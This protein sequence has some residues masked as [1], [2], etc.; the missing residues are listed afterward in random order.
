MLKFFIISVLLILQNFSAFAQ[1]SNI[2]WLRKNTHEFTDLSFIDEAVSKKQFVFLGESSHGAKE[3]YSLKARLTEYLVRKHGFE[4]VSFESP[5]TASY[6]YNE[7]K[8]SR[9]DTLSHV[10]HIL[11]PIFCNNTTKDLIIRLDSMKIPIVGFDYQLGTKFQARMVS[12]FVFSKLS[13]LDTTVANDFLETNKLF[14][15][16]NLV[17]FSTDEVWYN[18]PCIAIKDKLTCEYWLKKYNGFTNFLLTHYSQ[19]LT[20]CKNDKL[21]AFATINAVQSTQADLLTTIYNDNAGIRDSLMAKNIE[22]ITRI[23]YPNKKVIFWGHNE[24]ISKNYNRVNAEFSKDQKTIVGYLGKAFLAKSLVIGLY[25]I[26]GS[27]NNNKRAPVGI[28]AGS[29][30]STFEHKIMDKVEQQVYINL[31]NYPF[32]G[33]NNNIYICNW[34]IYTE[35]LN[36]RDKYDYLI[37]IKSLTPSTYL[38]NQ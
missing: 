25:G 20:V 27:T 36:P 16:D 26:D 14:T 33:S 19:L 18:Y 3:F 13:K 34:G 6:F 30:D 12:D 35:S 31:K 4:V 29:I 11:F 1:F 32:T 9:S 28:T 17:R 8:E 22:M 2:E 10:E 38:P 5:F 21:A 15:K 7:F 37:F 23:L 24:H